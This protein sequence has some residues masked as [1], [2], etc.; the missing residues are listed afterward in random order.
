MTNSAPLRL[1]PTADVDAEGVAVITVQ[2][3]SNVAYRVDQ[4]SVSGTSNKKSGTQT[5]AANIFHND[6][7]VCAS[8]SGAMDTA[9]DPPP[10]A[11]NPSETM[12]IT[13]SG[14]M[15]GTPVYARIVGAII[16]P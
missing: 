9:S 5:G 3:P 11:V 16:S 8:A 1:A 4:V 15:P 2:P 10:L 7:F 13:W 6:I 12:T 14:M